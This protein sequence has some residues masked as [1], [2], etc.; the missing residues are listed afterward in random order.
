MSDWTKTDLMAYLLFY[1]AKTDLK[2]TED[3]LAIISENVD[4]ETVSSIEKEINADNDIERIDKIN[5]YVKENK[6]SEE[7]I[8]NLLEEI[9]KIYEADGKFD[10]LERMTFSFLRKTW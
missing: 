2:V 8:D 5:S 10:R 1:A 4:A 3:E 7:E 9:K 6:C